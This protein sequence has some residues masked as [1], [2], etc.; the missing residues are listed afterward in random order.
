LKFNSPW[1]IGIDN[2]SNI[3]VYSASHGYNYGG[4]WESYNGNNIKE[5]K[6]GILIKSI[7]YTEDTQELNW[8]L[9]GLEWLD[10]GDNLAESGGCAADY[11]TK[12]Q[13][14][15]YD[16]SSKVRGKEAT[17]VGYTQNMLKYPNDPRSMYQ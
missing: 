14:W 8:Q 10:I 9:Y 3:Y 6:L 2:A 12:T 16:Y 13:H 11:Y 1:G 7:S 4:V 5:E 17:Y 15:V